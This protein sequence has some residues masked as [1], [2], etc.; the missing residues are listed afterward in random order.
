VLW[1]KA[2]DHVGVLAVGPGFLQVAQLAQQAAADHGHGAGSDRVLV[3]VDQALTASDVDRAAAEKDLAAADKEL[4][5]WS[6]E[7]DGAHAALVVRRGWAQARLD[8][9]DRIATH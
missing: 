4:A 2:T 7:L 6:G 9:A 5:S 3:L 1:Y 8:A